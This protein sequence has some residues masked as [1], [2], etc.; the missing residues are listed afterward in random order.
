ML[1]ML[2][3]CQAMPLADSA[4]SVV[5]RTEAPPKP[6][7]KNQVAK[8]SSNDTIPDAAEIGLAQQKS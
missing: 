3:G 6:V 2:P 4:N 7:R 1:G 8:P 5:E